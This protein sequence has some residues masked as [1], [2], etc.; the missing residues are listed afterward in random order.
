MARHVRQ[1]EGITREDPDG[2]WDLPEGMTVSIENPPKEDL[3]KE[4]IT[5]TFFPPGCSEKILTLSLGNY[6]DGGFVP[7]HV[8][9]A[10]HELPERI[11]LYRLWK[12]AIESEILLPNGRPVKNH[13][14]AVRWLLDQIGKL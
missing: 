2:G 3:P 11:G 7:R 14:D 13:T 5:G 6:P 10:L 8:D 12:G 1:V 9:L 4:P